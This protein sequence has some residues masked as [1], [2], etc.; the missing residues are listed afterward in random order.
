M[1][2]RHFVPFHKV[3]Y[4]LFFLMYIK[5]F[6]SVSQLSSCASGVCLLQFFKLV[7]NRGKTVENREGGQ[8][9]LKGL[10]I[11]FSTTTDHFVSAGRKSDKNN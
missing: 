11:I 4:L 6:Y 7:L 5:V 8:R 3:G 2:V 1:Y 9:S 10:K